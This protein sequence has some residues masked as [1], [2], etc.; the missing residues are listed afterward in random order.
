M[1]KLKNSNKNYNQDI[2]SEMQV[3]HFASQ[4]IRMFRF[5]FFFYWKTRKKND[6]WDR[7]GNWWS[8]IQTRHIQWQVRKECLSRLRAGRSAF[9]C[10]YARAL[11]GWAEVCKMLTCSWD[12]QMRR[13]KRRERGCRKYGKTVKCYFLRGLS[14]IFI[15]FS[16]F[17]SLPWVSPLTFCSFKS[18]YSSAC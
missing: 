2:V 13:K 6:F 10:F 4:V 17:L 11:T 7:L 3:Q 18:L 1:N 15:L 16:Y 5:F 8:E 12:G 14:S 9:L